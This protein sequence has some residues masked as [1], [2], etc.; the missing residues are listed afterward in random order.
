MKVDL[1]AYDLFLKG[2]VGKNKVKLALLLPEDALAPSQL[3]ELSRSTFSVFIQVA[4]PEIS[5]AA[6]I[7]RLDFIQWSLNFRTI[8]SKILPDCSSGRTSL[9]VLTITEPVCNASGVSKCELPLL[10][11][12][13]VTFPARST[14][15]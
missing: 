2:V 14:G 6:F 1:L 3:F 9:A 11:Y 13:V 15:S 12:Q 5:H 10:K 4:F 7:L 8:L